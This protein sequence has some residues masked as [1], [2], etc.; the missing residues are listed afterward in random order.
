[1][2][3]QARLLWET[4][5]HTTCISISWVTLRCYRVDSNGV[6]YCGVV[7]C[8]T[9]YCVLVYCGEVYW[10]VVYCGVAYCGEVYCGAVY[11]GVIVRSGTPAMG[12]CRPQY[13]FPD[14]KS[15][16]LSWLRR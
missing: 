7:Y 10:D 8:G 13:L 12:H 1:M 9:V 4:V 5:D 2:S 3:G 11:C 14:M 6:A 15:S 16:F